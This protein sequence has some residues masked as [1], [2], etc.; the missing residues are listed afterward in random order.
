M[1]MGGGMPEAMLQRLLSGGEL[2]DAETC[3]WIKRGFARWLAPNDKISMP[4][5]FGLHG[6]AALVS[7]RMRDLW[8]REA[9]RY[10]VDCSPWPRAKKLRSAAHEFL[11]HPW[12]VWRRATEP[13]WSRCSHLQACLF[14]AA[15]AQADFPKTDRQFL[16]IIIAEEDRPDDFTT[17][18]RI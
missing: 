12:P 5:A 7:V 1:K 18:L 8:L 6:S 17:L 13:P 2:F 11:S 15:R 4:A 10:I 16:T 3:T 9:G 14:F